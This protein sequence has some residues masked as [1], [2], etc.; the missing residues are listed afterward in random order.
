MNITK[1]TA[2]DAWKAALIYIMTKG[3]D[4]RFAWI[5]DFPLFEWNG[6]DERW[7]A[8]HHMFTM[9]QESYLDTLE[10][11]KRVLGDDHPET[12][13]AMAAD[14]AATQAWTRL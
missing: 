7:E 12:L 14:P 3:K 8:A 10:K 9:P 1:P 11:R 2:L 4:F 5:I 6:D 13:T